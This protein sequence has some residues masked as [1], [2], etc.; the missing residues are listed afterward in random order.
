MLKAKGVQYTTAILITN[1]KTASLNPK[2]YFH[3]SSIQQLL[4]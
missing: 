2:H 1:S 3:D 4:Y